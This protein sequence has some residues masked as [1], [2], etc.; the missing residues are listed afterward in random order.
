MT[1]QMSHSWSFVLSFALA[2]SVGLAAC[3]GCSQSNGQAPSTAD[4][5]VPKVPTVRL[6]LLSTVAGALEPCG[7]SKDQLGGVDHL[8]AYIESQKEDAPNSLVLGAGPLLFTEPVL[9]PDARTQREWNAEAMA[10][11]ASKLGLVAWAPGANDWAGGADA[12]STL[13]GKASATV[14]A[15][16][17]EGQK[18]LIPS[19]LLDVGGTKVGVVGV[20]NPTA[21]LGTATA[22]LFPSGFSPGP[23]VDAMKRE[24]ASLKGQGAKIIVGLASL[25]RG[26]ALRLAEA[27]PELHV[28]AVGKPIQKGDA[29][30]ALKPAVLVGN[31]VVVESANHLQSV[32]VLDLYVRGTPDGDLVFADAG[33]VQKA[34]DI[35]SLATR[36]R[37]LE[38]RINGWENDESI[39]PKDVAARKEDLENLRK[40]KSEYEKTET[41]AK[42]S[43]F[44]Y[45]AVEVRESLGKDPAVSAVLASYYAKVND[46]NKEAFKD[47]KP[48]P[49]E[50]GKA[51]FIGVEECTLCHEEERDV[52][53]KTPHA[54]AY[55]TLVKD[56]KEFNLD[57]VGCHVTGYD[58]PGG[59]TVTHVDRLEAV[60][61]EVCH[62]PGSLHAKDPEKE[63]L[64]ILKP[65]P[66]TCVSE[67]HHPP[68]VEGFDPEAKLKHILGPGHG[69]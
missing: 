43:F 60:G 18:Q 63:G 52:W 29:N 32:A 45:T 65:D 4:D 31:T 2:A 50:D 9:E 61:C 57:C 41:P 6:Y 40:T 69:E 3:Q 66:K 8:A 11:A 30:D 51:S 12:L 37:D 22:D 21:G 38:N 36:I 10:E 24:I 14:L 13:S 44:R 16:N 59:S 47:R 33:G 62:G 48:R 28:L 35:V 27:V 20:A 15:A 53:D 7:C 25:P 39:D 58:L 67:C 46:Y 55:E 54:K 23:A 49:A 26:D 56:H 17:I 5:A 42:G 1:A 34:E 64:V 19:K 68:H